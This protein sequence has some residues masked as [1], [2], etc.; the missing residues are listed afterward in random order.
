MDAQGL[1]PYLWICT[2]LLV[3]RVAGQ[4]VVVLWAPSWLPPMDRWQSGLVPYWFLLASQAVVL[5][6]MCSISIDFT[7]GRGFWVG[8]HSWLG[9]AAYYWSYLYATAMLVRYVVRMTRYPG[10]R[11]FGGTIPILF[12]TVVAAFQWTFGLFQVFGA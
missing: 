3:C 2:A 4:L 11:W 8:P 6:L 9:A 12:H 1:A 10:E 7:R 5:Y